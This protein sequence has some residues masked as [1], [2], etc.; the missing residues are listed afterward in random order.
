MALRSMLRIAVF[1]FA[2]VGWVA[3]VPTAVQAVCGDQ[4]LDPGEDCDDGNTSDGDCCSA[5]CTFQAAGQGTPDCCNAT[6]GCRAGQ[7]CAGGCF[8]PEDN[9][10]LSP[11]GCNCISPGVCPLAAGEYTFRQDPGGT[12]KVATLSPFPFP[13]G[14]T[15]VTD[16]GP[17]NAACVHSAVV[18]PGGLNTPAFCIAALNFTV[19]VAQDPALT[20]GAG[21]VDSDGGSDFDS[22]EVGD[23]SDS[24]GPCGLPHGSGG[25]FCTL[26]VDQSMR[27]R[28]TIGNGA[29]DPCT[30]PGQGNAFTVIPAETTVW[31]AAD[32]SCP[33]GDGTYDP[34]TDTLSSILTQRLVF[35]TASA[36][37]SWAD[38]DGDGCSFA[39]VGPG[40]QATVSGTCLNYPDRTATLVA[41]G[42]IGS[43][44]SP[45]F[46]NSFVTS[47]VNTIFVTG[48]FSGTTCSPGPLTSTG[49]VCIP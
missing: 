20:C 23:T 49:D 29:A 48:S 12:L 28:R 35:T 32:L 11:T 41:E 9:C 13:A 22:V 34:G 6:G 5:T 10:E 7:I 43:A 45:L 19:Q 37:T 14:G 47:L 36:T 40:S 21:F 15:L 25:T 30:P 4:V 24:T 26:G 8:M 33:D 3:V 38:L 17:P 1:L 39:G 27:I 18:P 31:T 44:A 2:V 46:D 42:P 16:V